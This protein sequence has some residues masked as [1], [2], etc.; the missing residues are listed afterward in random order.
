M[1][2]CTLCGGTGLVARTGMPAD[3]TGVTSGAATATMAWCGHCHG[4]GH[5]PGPQ[6]TEDSPAIS[7]NAFTPQPWNVYVN[8]R[9]PGEAFCVMGAPLSLYF[10]PRYT[11]GVSETDP[12]HWEFVTTIGNLPYV[13]WTT[14]A[15][16]NGQNLPLTFFH[17]SILQASWI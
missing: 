2:P 3:L 5:E 13:Q 6:H 17:G 1:S 11:P 16:A 4:T 15:R 7:R 10:C 14:P 12:S 8:P 9:K